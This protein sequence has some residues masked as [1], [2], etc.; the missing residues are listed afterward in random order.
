MP[1]PDTVN[2]P[3]TD[4]GALRLIEVVGS[5]INSPAIVL[6][7]FPANTKLPLVMPVGFTV[8]V[9][10]PSVKLIPVK[11]LTSNA[12]PVKLTAPVSKFTSNNLPTL[13]CPFWSTE[14]K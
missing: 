6:I 1:P 3:V 10:V 7:V 4:V 14:L 12:G 2:C 9:C 13:K 5:N 8:V 11:L